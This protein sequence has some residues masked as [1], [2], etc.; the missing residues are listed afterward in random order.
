MIEI[1]L[2][3]GA[4]LAVDASALPR[5]ETAVELPPVE[6][7]GVVGATLVARRGFTDGVE[8]LRVACVRAPSGRW[9]PGVEGLV[10]DRA[11]A[12]AKETL[13]PLERWSATAPTSTAGRF[14]QTLQGRSVDR[15]AV[16]R[17][18]LGFIGSERD[19]VLCTTTC[20]A[21]QT[22]SC[23]ERVART[24]AHGAFVEAPPV[25]LWVQTIL[26][27]ATKPYEAAGWGAALLVMVVSA[28]LW[29]R[30]RPRP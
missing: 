11:T 30:P 29:R 16:L 17:H 9:A 14:E 23:A 12:M 5:Q 13:P 27:A 10:L 25:N 22:G 21:P 20:V 18:V 3:D 6:L 2:G 24:S 1:A 4:W 28:V 19:A 26:F 7:A 8:I 15:H